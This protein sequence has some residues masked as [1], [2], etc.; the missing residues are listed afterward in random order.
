MTANEWQ[1][2]ETAPKDGSWFLAFWPVHS[3][4][5]Q[6]RVTSYE[7]AINDGLGAFLDADDW[8]DWTQPTHW[9]TLPAP[10]VVTP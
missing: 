3:R 8:C 1:A 5:D 2:I 10:P 9:M 4:E 6:I 7:W